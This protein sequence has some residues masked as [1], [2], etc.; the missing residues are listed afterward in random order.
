MAGPD[1]IDGNEVQD[2]GK[3]G[4]CHLN[5]TGVT[6]AEVGEAAPNDG[7]TGSPVLSQAFKRACAKLG[8]VYPLRGS[9]VLRFESG[10]P[11]LSEHVSLDW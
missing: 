9:Q 5:T 10:E 1:R 3:A 4:V 8:S 11:R 2:F 6:R 7:N